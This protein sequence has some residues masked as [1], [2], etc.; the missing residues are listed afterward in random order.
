[1]GLYW[2]LGGDT[3]GIVSPNLDM[4]EETTPDSVVLG[5]NSCNNKLVS[6][7]VISPY[8]G[9]H[10]LGPIST[11]LNKETLFGN[12]YRTEIV[13]MPFLAPLPYHLCYSS[14]LRN[15]NPTSV[16]AEYYQHSFDL[17]SDAF[18]VLSLPTQ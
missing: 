15:S 18:S 9:I 13:C 3:V 17:A 7:L 6:Y 2:P 12:R 5:G 1:M 10:T 14:D 4:K 8:S 11:V 16:R